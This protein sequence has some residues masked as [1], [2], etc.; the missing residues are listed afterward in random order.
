MAENK[1]VQ[2]FID[3]NNSKLQ[4]KYG[5]KK[6]DGVYTNDQFIKQHQKEFADYNRYIGFYSL[7]KSA[8]IQ[9]PGNAWVIAWWYAQRKPLADVTPQW[10]RSIAAKVNAVSSISQMVNVLPNA[11]PAIYAETLKQLDDNNK[12]LAWMAKNKNAI[13]I[14]QRYNDKTEYHPLNEPNDKIIR[15]VSQGINNLQEAVTKPFTNVFDGIKNVF[16]NIP[17]VALW[18]GAGLVAVLILKKK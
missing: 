1:F 18:V 12:L 7:L 5:V 13:A 3:A 2:A 8:G 17:T 10:A 9:T 15:N 16:S 11:S 6:A 4:E 14:A